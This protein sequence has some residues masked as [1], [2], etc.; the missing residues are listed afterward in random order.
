MK[1]INLLLVSL[2]LFSM[3]ALAQNATPSERADKRVQEISNIVS[4]TPVQYTQAKQ[5]M[6]T[7]FTKVDALRDNGSDRDVVREQQQTIM[8]EAKKQIQALLTD[9]QAEKM[10]TAKKSRGE[11]EPRQRN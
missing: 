10:R 1:R 2:S 4:L 7:A 11:R 3:S 5:I 9:E 8:R 6:T